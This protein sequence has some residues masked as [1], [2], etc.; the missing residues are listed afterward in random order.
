MKKIFCP[1]VIGVLALLFSVSSC[2][3]IWDEIKHHPDGAADNCRIE[4]VYFTEHFINPDGAADYILF[5]DTADF[6]YNAKEQLAS[7]DYA[8]QAHDLGWDV[9]PVMGQ[10]FKYDSKGRLQGYF[11]NASIQGTSISGQHAHWYTYSSDGKTVVDSIGTYTGSNTAEDAGWLYSSA[12]FYSKIT[13]DAYGRIVKEQY[14]DGTVTNYSY[15]SKGNLIKPGV[16]YTIKTNIFQTNK[17]L[18]FVSRDYSMNAATGYASQFNS[19]QLPVKINS[20]YLPLVTK[21]ESVILDP[22]EHQNISVK[23]KCE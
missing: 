5:N 21:V 15:D 14:G 8:S 12:D 4:T 6:K 2:K 19:N 22:Y 17:A 16:T 11:M 3:K 18:M 9:Y 10:V 13:L 23:Y 1:H 20:G 7:I